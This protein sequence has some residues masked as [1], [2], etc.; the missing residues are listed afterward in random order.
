MQASVPVALTVDDDSSC[1]DA[2]EVLRGFLVDSVGF[3][4]DAGAITCDAAAGGRRR[5]L[6]QGTEFPMTAEVSGPGADWVL[7]SAIM[8]DS[9]VYGDLEDSFDGALTGIT[10][11][12]PPPPPEAPPP[13]PR[14]APAD[15]GEQ[16]A[17]APDGQQPEEDVAGAGGGGDDGDDST[18]IIIIAVVAAVAL[19]VI[20]IAL[21]LWRSKGKKKGKEEHVGSVKSKPP[22]A[23]VTVDTPDGVRSQD[24]YMLDSGQAHGVGMVVA[25][26]P[27]SVQSG[28]RD[29]RSTAD[30]G[31][32]QGTVERSTVSSGYTSMPGPPGSTAAAADAAAAAAAD[33][34]RAAPPDPVGRPAAAWG[35][36]TAAFSTTVLP[37]TGDEQDLSRT[38]GDVSPQPA[39]HSP[40][41]VG[42]M[43]STSSDMSE[44][45]VEGEGSMI[46]RS[47]S[48]VKTTGNAR[49][50][51]KEP[52]PVLPSASNNYPHSEE[53]A[54][55]SS[56]EIHRRMRSP[57][58]SGSRK[59]KGGSGGAS[60]AESAD[61]K[62][63]AAKG[64][65]LSD[66][67]AGITPPMS[68]EAA[69]PAGGYVAAAVAGGGGP[70]SITPP[71]SGS[72]APGVTAQAEAARV[73]D[74]YAA[75]NPYLPVSRESPEVVD[76]KN[77]MSLRAVKRR[78]AASGG[79]S[80]PTS[81]DDF[82]ARVGNTFM[83]GFTGELSQDVNTAGASAGV[84]GGLNV[85]ADDG[86]GGDSGDS[87]GNVSVSSFTSV[88]VMSESTTVYTD[89]GC[90]PPAALPAAAV[91]LSLPPAMNGFVS[92]RHRPHLCLSST[93]AVC[94]VA[95]GVRVS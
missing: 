18:R 56:R 91:R 82:S 53:L 4:M 46:S 66:D 89:V 7:G 57:A 33:A 94:H 26:E 69:R 38:P 17:G 45:S 51:S 1:E 49:R 31:V 44:M 11:D 40:G 95:G 85:P 13:P 75:L 78:T 21:C 68:A 63:D 5:R 55:M 43:P 22:A 41:V 86:S 25:K 6:L 34:Y 72:A 74:T 81:P 50:S 93:A 59:S 14:D 58:V 48:K 19:I 47:L 92:G 83:M 87:R 10:A 64:D 88:S 61:S 9:P 23:Y 15:D 16:T 36:N 8:Q 71:Q 29:A 67:A 65:T 12:A 80:E 54:K 2:A 62:P 84:T 90:A 37:V 3:A 52:S 28:D 73:R 27:V 76:E 70:A 39:T 79:V 24:A 42:V 20:V 30:S 32:V 77:G 60:K 35:T